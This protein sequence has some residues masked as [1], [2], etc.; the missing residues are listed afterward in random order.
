MV[1]TI[2]A[3]TPTIATVVFTQSD[4]K[5]GLIT[6]TTLKQGRQSKVQTRAY[7]GAHHVVAQ[8]SFIYDAYG[9]LA[10]RLETGIGATSY[11]YDDAGR[12]ESVT[13]PDP[14]PLNDGAGQRAQTITYTYV[15]LGAS[16][17]YGR[18]ETVAR[19][20]G[21]ASGT[22]VEQTV[23][24]FYPTGELRLTYG[25][26][27]TPS[28]YFYD[29]AGRMRTL[30]TWQNFNLS[31]GTGSGP[32]ETTTWY[33][34]DAGL[35]KNKRDAANYGPDYTYYTSGTLHTRK[36]ARSVGG[37]RL[38]ATYDYSLAGDLEA[39]AYSDGTT[40]PVSHSYDRAGRIETT[41][42]AAGFLT[43]TYQS[44]RLAGESY[45]GAGDLSARSITR[46]FDTRLRQQSLGTDGGYAVSYTYDDAGRLDTA[47][48]GFHLAKYSYVANLG[49]VESVIIKRTGVERVRHER[50]PDPLRRVARTKSLVG[51][52][53]ISDRIYS[54]DD[55]N[56]RT[57]VV[58]EDARRWAY[59]YD[60]LGQVESAEKRLADNST[61][62]PGYAFNYTYDSA[63]NRVST[64]VNGRSATYT[65]N[66]LNEYVNRDVPGA[67]DVRGEADIEAAVTVNSLSSTRVGK[68]F[69]REINASNTSA[70]AN[71]SLTIGAILGGDTVVEAR[72]GF[73]PQTPEAF[74]HDLDG[75]LKQDGRWEYAWDAENRLVRMETRASIASAFPDLKKRLTFRYDS[76]GRRIRKIVETWDVG[77]S[78]WIEGLDLLFLYDGWNLLTELDANNSN[79]LVRA[80]AWG[81]DASGT[82]QGAGGVGGLLWTSTPTHTFVPCFDGNGNPTAWVNTGTLAVSGRADYG[83]FGE[84]V[85]QTGVAATLPFGFSTKYTDR[86]TNLLYYG[87]RYLDAST[88][89]WLSR[90][91]MQERGG[92]NLYG[93]V[94]NDAI[95]AID[96]WGLGTW[97]VFE[98]GINLSGPGISPEA[99]AYANPNGFEV[100]YFPDPGECPDGKIVIYQVISR[101]GLDGALAHV[102]GKLPPDDA[103]CR[104]PPG[105]SPIGSTSCSYIDSPTGPTGYA[106]V[107]RFKI[108]A[109]AVC[110]SK[111]KD[112]K[113]S[114]YFFV[115]DNGTRKITKRDPGYEDHYEDG[116]EDF[117]ERVNDK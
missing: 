96:L 89:R 117:N 94:G 104:L 58:M 63:G 80:H 112:T 90:D 33:Y 61:M 27:T 71:P 46:G 101:V 97:K 100:Q 79:A 8:I 29:Y 56:R 47:S 39:V 24:E 20:H 45:T 49:S 26:G 41:T 53:A 92:L 5:R 116:L 51:G 109:V 108:T 62:L 23:S 2:R 1:A 17:G 6:E 16:A 7:D 105:M 57:G 9:R 28:R 69:Y 38:M 84:V 4:P 107:K 37:G 60:A 52:S 36:W 13:T 91:P 3:A 34:N 66:A 14:D 113:L 12:I 77:M 15:D 31:T 102:D 98:R 48:H 68:D 88:G 22:I 73:L 59:G 19:R 99:A 18:R 11:S 115:F 50:I 103:P 30:T 10:T 65:P 21:G 76:Q 95:N 55:A 32:G 111:C 74:A 25:P 67:I 87:Y 64:S 114:T 86:E 82:L 78:E 110:R 72:N 54:Y 81:L 70:A 43:R 83:A 35:L 40:P 42:D 75:N 93:M 106:G 44:G 85:M